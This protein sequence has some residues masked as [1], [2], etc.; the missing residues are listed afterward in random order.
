LNVIFIEN[1]FSFWESSSERIQ[2]LDDF[3]S[4]PSTSTIQPSYNNI[5][6]LLIMEIIELN[7]GIKYSQGFFVIM[8]PYIRMDCF[9]KMRF[10]NSVPKMMFKL[11]LVRMFR[12]I[13]SLHNFESLLISKSDFLTFQLLYEKL[14]ILWMAMSDASV[15]CTENGSHIVLTTVLTDVWFYF[16]PRYFI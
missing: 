11:F 16:C 15:Q 7:K 5:E 12:K 3:S 4:F 10:K 9:D 6:Q 2:F 13:E 1:F 14:C 8:Y